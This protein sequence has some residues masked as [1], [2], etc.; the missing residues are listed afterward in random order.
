MKTPHQALLT[1]A[2]CLALAAPF[3]ALADRS[4]PPPKMGPQQHGLMPAM[5]PPPPGGEMAMPGE[6]P[7]PPF[8][9]G[10]KLSE[11]QQDAL[12]AIL[13]QS[14]PAARAAAK[15]AR[16]AS[17]QLQ[18]LTQ[19]EKFDD[20]QARIL[21]ESAAK[22]MADLLLLRTRTE[23]KVIA[24]LNAEQRAALKAAPPARRGMPVPR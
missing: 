15:A 24:L 18:A 16:K 2:L 9:H 19:A 12:F 1:G 20:E 22:A 4:L 21:A 10:M 11:E 3:A 17:E 7:L 13:H 8:L 14:A 23:Q 5:F 6:M